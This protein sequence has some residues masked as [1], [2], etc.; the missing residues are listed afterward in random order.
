MVE[1][2]IKYA[3]CVFIFRFD[4]DL[5]QFTV[6]FG[7][8]L[9][10]SIAE[11]PSGK[12]LLQVLPGVFYTHSR[13]AHLYK[14]GPGGVVKGIDTDGVTLI[15]QQPDRLREL[16]HEIDTLVLGPS[17]RHT[18]AADGLVRLLFEAARGHPVPSDTLC[19]VQYDIPFRR[20]GREGIAVESHAPGRRQLHAHA[21]SQHHRVVAGAD[22][23]GTM[24]ELHLPLCRV[25]DRQQGDV[26]Q[27]ADTCSAEVHLPESDDRRVAVM[28]AGT[29]VPALLLLC[30]TRLNVSERNIG[31]EEHMAVSA[32]SDEWVDILRV[33]LRKGE[34]S[35]GGKCRQC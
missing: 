20:I 32:C 12:L 35:G 11:I 27:V 10:D 34:E 3:L 22:V 16:C 21:G 8:R 28:I 9:D 30:R 6:P 17:C 24:G 19:E 1:C 23:L 33:V 15:F 4:G 31:S 7:F 14:E 13:D 26:S 25:G 5:A 2:R 18:E 29:P